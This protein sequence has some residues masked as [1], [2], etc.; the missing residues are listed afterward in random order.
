MLTLQSFLLLP[1]SLPFPHVSSGFTQIQGYQPQRDTY[2]LRAWET[3]KYC[4]QINM[5]PCSFTTA[6]EWMKLPGRVLSSQP[7]FRTVCLELDKGNR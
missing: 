6:N 1:F 7:A 4:L 5:A 3:E 2:I